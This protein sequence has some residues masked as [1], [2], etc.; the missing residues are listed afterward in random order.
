MMNEQVHQSLG[1]LVIT[2]RRRLHLTQE[3]LARDMF[4]SR[5]EI[6]LIEREH[7]QGIK[8]IMLFR[9]SETLALPMMDVVDAWL[10]SCWR[11]MDS[12]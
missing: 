12:V 7:S 2:A 10:E 9:L 1:E 4:V 5:N 8:A 3:K 6:G 11:H